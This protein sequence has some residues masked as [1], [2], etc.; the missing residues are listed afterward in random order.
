MCRPP[1]ACLVGLRT[2]YRNFSRVGEGFDFKT[3][4]DLWHQVVLCRAGM[5]L[6]ASPAIC[7]CI[8]VRAFASPQEFESAKELVRRCLRDPKRQEIIQSSHRGGQLESN[9]QG[10]TS[11]CREPAKKEDAGR[12]LRSPGAFW[13]GGRCWIRTSDLYRVKVTL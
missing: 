13:S 8:P 10:R 2:L 3:K 5:L 11:R 9:R 6:Y 7:Y 12:P 4:W 1:R